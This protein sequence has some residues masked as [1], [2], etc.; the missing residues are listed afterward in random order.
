MDT[1]NDSTDVENVS[2]S[3]PEKRRSSKPL[4]EK[5]RRARINASLTELKTFLLDMIKKEGLRHNK[6]EKA[7]ILELTVK[8]LRQLKRHSIAEGGD[9]TFRTGFSECAAE[10]RK[11]LS[12]IP[13]LETN[14]QVRLLEHLSLC[15]EK[16]NI[17]KDSDFSAATECSSQY[18]YKISPKLDN[19]A[20]MSTEI[21]CSS[22]VDC[23]GK[24]Q[25][26]TME[27][28]KI[29]S[30]SPSA[31]TVQHQSVPVLQNTLCQSLASTGLFNSSVCN[32]HQQIN[33]VQTTNS[34][35]QFG[36]I[37]SG[38][39]VLPVRLSSGQTAYIIPTNILANTCLSG[40]VLPVLTAVNGVQENSSSSAEFNCLDQSVKQ[41]QSCNITHQSNVAKVSMSM[42]G[43][44]DNV[45]RGISNT[46]NE[47]NLHVYGQ[48]YLHR[49]VKDPVWR[50]W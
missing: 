36:N 18:N 32:I 31:P 21:L 43:P 12:S 13:E 22:Y 44:S 2:S 49:N 42:T 40:N 8:H 45:S 29:K 41:I 15:I 20:P 48:Q 23:V 37:I 47:N 35:I 6:M 24:C 3:I 30:P 34:N 50:P 10:V 11:F 16:H 38:L 28:Q 14:L 1:S 5:R 7:D 27:S 19:K 17:S 33:T 9:E 46:I 4:M 25:N 39:Q 26:G